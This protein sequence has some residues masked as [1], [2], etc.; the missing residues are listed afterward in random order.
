MT[1]WIAIAHLFTTST[2]SDT[3][4]VRRF[5]SITIGTNEGRQSKSWVFATAL[6]LYGADSG[7]Y[8]SSSSTSNNKDICSHIMEGG[9]HY[10]ILLIFWN[11]RSNNQWL[12]KTKQTKQNKTAAVHFHLLFL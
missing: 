5:K 10:V 3:F 4:M 12:K 11:E 1:T 8:S 9:A 7:M 2:G 6:E